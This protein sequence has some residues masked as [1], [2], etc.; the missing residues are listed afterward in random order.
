MIS[1]RQGEFLI[2][3]ENSV[4]EILE[5]EEDVK[6]SEQKRLTAQ[7]NAIAVLD[8]INSLQEEIKVSQLVLRWKDI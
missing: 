4:E 1:R 8:M 2:D 3:D 5:F 6:L 7:I